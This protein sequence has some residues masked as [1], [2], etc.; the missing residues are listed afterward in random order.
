MA[1]YISKG[2]IF[3]ILY[4]LKHTYKSKYMGF[5]RVWDEIKDWEG[6]NEPF[7]RCRNCANGISIAHKNKRFYCKVFDCE[8]PNKGFCYR[9]VE[10]DG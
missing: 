10:K 1:E 9:G 5:W 7:V 4:Q 2:D 3:E 6:V 8:V